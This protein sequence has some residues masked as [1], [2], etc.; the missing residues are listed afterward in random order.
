MQRLQHRAARV[1]STK[2]TSSG[3]RHACGVCMLLRV[4][5][6]FVRGVVASAPF[7]CT[8]VLVTSLIGPTR[9]LKG[10]CGRGH[11]FTVACAH[12]ISSRLRTNMANVPSSFSMSNEQVVPNFLFHFF[13]LTKLPSLKKAWAQ[14][15]LFLV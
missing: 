6:G 5:A 8:S 2:H 10:S 3:S 9:K 14:P 1:A 11:I 13:F 7:D 4:W 15:L 12:P